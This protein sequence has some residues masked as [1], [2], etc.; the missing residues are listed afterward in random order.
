MG[1]TFSCPLSF[2][3]ASLLAL[4]TNSV[5]L[6]FS[7]LVNQP[8]P[9]APLHPMFQVWSSSSPP[10]SRDGDY[11]G[12]HAHHDHYRLL[13]RLCLAADHSRTPLP[14]LEDF[15]P[16]SA[17]VLREYAL[18]FGVDPLHANLME[19][20]ALEAVLA[21]SGPLLRRI[22]SVLRRLQARPA[23]TASHITV[24][25][26]N[27]TPAVIPGAGSGSTAETAAGHDNGAAGLKSTGG[28]L[29][30]PP[31]LPTRT[32][33]NM[34]E[35]VRLQTALAG[36]RRHLA[37]IVEHLPAL[38]PNG[39][40]AAGA[41]SA[42]M[43]LLDA[44]LAAQR[45]RALETGTTPGGTTTT[46][47][48]A[49]LHDSS[50]TLSP[51]RH[52]ARQSTRGS[53]R[54]RATSASAGSGSASTAPSAAASAAA[55]L[56]AL[57]QRLVETRL[58]YNKAC[59]LGLPP[60][61]L[62]DG[63]VDDRNTARAHA[64]RLRSASLRADELQRMA[65]LTAADL[66]QWSALLG[67]HV[68]QIAPRTICVRAAYTSLLGHARRLCFAHLAGGTGHEIDS[69]LLQTA[70]FLRLLHHRWA[71][72]LPADAELQWQDAFVPLTL[73]WLEQAQD[74]A[75]QAL[76]QT[77]SVERFAD[78]P[79]VGVAA[80]RLVMRDARRHLHALLSFGQ[81]LVQLFV[82]AD[83]TQDQAEDQEERDG[84]KV[85][86]A[87]TGTAAPEPHAATTGLH[88]DGA[89]MTILPAVT[90]PS[91][92]HTSAAAS[93]AGPAT[94][95]PTVLALGQRDGMQP[96]LASPNIS[97]CV[98]HHAS[99]PPSPSREAPTRSLTL[100]GRRALPALGPLPRVL[101]G[102]HSA[103]APAPVPIR[104]NEG[105][106]QVVRHLHLVVHSL[107]R[108]LMLGILRHDMPPLH[109]HDRQPNPTVAGLDADFCRRIDPHNALASR[110][111]AHDQSWVV[112]DH[113]TNSTALQDDDIVSGVTDDMD[114]G[115]HSWAQELPSGLLQDAESPLL[116]APLP[117][118]HSKT[119]HI[120]ATAVAGA[121][122]STSTS[123]PTSTPRSLNARWRPSSASAP[124]S[125][126]ATPNS[127]P[128]R[129]RPLR[130]HSSLRG[131]MPSSESGVHTTSE[132]ETPFAA[133]FA[134]AGGVTLSRG[135]SDS[136][137]NLSDGSASQTSEP[138]RLLWRR[139][140]TAGSSLPASTVTS[141]RTSPVLE[142]LHS[143]ASKTQE[144]T[145]ER[146]AASAHVSFQRL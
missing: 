37:R 26:I 85:S 50:T 130:T 96:P 59:V 122:A 54:P 125:S 70:A 110:G 18:Q 3:T 106:R 74:A 105:G 5:L 38:Y 128:T 83:D 107:L 95:S 141:R 10:E 119:A 86:A 43:R 13:L 131:E 73:R 136:A 57:L 146:A 63:N 80:A 103:L 22:V 65:L 132:E 47:S 27:S 24:R 118:E 98:S 40:G 113:P 1:F 124:A 68:P 62:A 51:S 30:S 32:R 6:S 12:L 82:T 101:S 104:I 140:M 102:P 34:A 137:C 66:A 135:Y 69:S 93:V 7:R 138:R 61:L 78:P 133:S 8:C 2:G 35:A 84:D 33:L 60:P 134:A 94:S 127:L 48:T 23:A 45:L 49:A 11:H 16:A 14:A 120:E 100:L 117:E 67:P 42:A 142:R 52:S 36:L 4:L 112:I 88:E 64:G 72:L 108:N 114:G 87:S 129:T 116:R 126:M 115:M 111:G 55:T 21:P 121:M 92:G 89:A 97:P 25:D 17:R 15:L 99:A 90:T 19:L 58:L 41:V 75:E 39:M 71:P 76:A 81:T 29:P 143:S 145:I 31:F 46:R 28:T 20:E 77:L 91:K 123:T 139:G 53:S 79:P 144:A 56:A 109:V 9:V 44:V